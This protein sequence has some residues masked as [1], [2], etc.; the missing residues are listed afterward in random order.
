MSSNLFFQAVYVES[1]Y[2]HVMDVADLKKKLAANPDCKHVMIS[3]MRGKV[4]DMDA[5]KT[6]CDEAGAILLEDCAHSLGVQWKGKHTGHVG[7]ASAISSQSYKMINSGEGGFFLTDDPLIA[8]KAAVYAG[9][10]EGL[11][12][13]HITVPGPE[14]F[15]DLPNQLPN[16]SLRMSNLAA[17]VVRP[18]LKT[19]E[20]RIEKYNRRYWKLVE[21]LSGRVGHLMTIPVDT[22]GMNVAVHDSFQFNLDKQFTPEMIQVFLKECKAHGLPVELFGDKSNARN[23]VN[24]GFAPAE[25][26]LPMTT[27]MLSRACD[28]RMP[29]MWDDED[30]DDMANVLVESLQ[31]A[32]AK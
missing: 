26:P 19:L 6:A 21:N 17:A 27:D 22:P 31:V 30:F 2:N 20:P 4:A 1:D 12:G 14:V 18:Q 23:F 24:W 29:L 10:Y 15:G 13:K 3:H 7:I 9:A 32:L 16:Y 5:I 25:D 8:A 11:A 28:V